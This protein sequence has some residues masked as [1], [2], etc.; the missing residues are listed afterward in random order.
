M[1]DNQLVKECLRGDMERFRKI[2]EKYR[3]K[4]MAMAVNI[5]GNREDAEDPCQETFLQTYRHLGG[6][7]TIHLRI[8]QF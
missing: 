2:V 8:I 3:G 4:A 1:N 7:R 5:L 6:H